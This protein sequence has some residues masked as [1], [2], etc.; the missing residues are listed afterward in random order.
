MYIT[1]PL[2]TYS[3]NESFYLGSS[4]VD[5]PESKLH[6]WPDFVALRKAL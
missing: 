3:R 1:Y 4:D 2:I 5:S 6:A